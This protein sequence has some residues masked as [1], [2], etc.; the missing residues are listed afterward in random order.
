MDLN[1]IIRVFILIA[2][3]S[4]FNKIIILHNAK[5]IRYGEVI[6]EDT[7]GKKFQG[8]LIK[9]DSNYVVIYCNERERY[10][11][12]RENV[13][14][15]KVN[16]NIDTK[17]V[18]KKISFVANLFNALMQKAFSGELKNMK[19]KKIQLILRYVFLIMFF[20]GFLLFVNRKV[21]PF[22]PSETF[23]SACS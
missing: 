11:F 23:L 8:K 17:K 13:K 5:N 1:S 2:T 20:L 4:T 10:T 3:I 9:Q 18:E 15:I 16:V 6:L 12:P 7:N 19:R 14:S 22:L 21:H